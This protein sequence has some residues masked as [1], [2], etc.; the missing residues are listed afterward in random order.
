MLGSCRR[1]LDAMLLQNKFKDLTHEVPS[2]LMRVVCAMVNSR[3]LVPV[4]SDP[5]NPSV[6]WL[7][8]LLTQ[9]SAL[10]CGSFGQVEF[11]T[12][13]AMR[14]QWKLVQYV[15][16]LFWSRWQTEYIVP[17]PIQDPAIQWLSLSLCYILV[18]RSIFCTI[19]MPL[20]FSVDL[21]Y[22]CH[23]GDFYS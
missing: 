9:K 15:A 8:L 13:N 4:S 10:S 18:F 11:G 1:I 23:F 21:F 14:S 2:T 17:V 12:N 5:E 3:P 19:I 6:I 22:I 7:S 16:D 20:V